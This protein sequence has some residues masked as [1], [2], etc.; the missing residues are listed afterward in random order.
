MVPLHSSTERVNGEIRSW[1]DVL[2]S[3]FAAGIRIFSFQSVWEVNRAIAPG[4][5]KL[6]VGFHLFEMETQ[7]FEQNIGKHRHPI[8]FTF[9]IANNDL[10]IREEK[11]LDAQAHNLHKTK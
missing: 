3:K 5:V 7:G 10:A 4:K 2:P 11:I 9:P 6:V 8:V 1:K